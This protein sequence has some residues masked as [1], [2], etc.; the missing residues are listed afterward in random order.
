M[1]RDRS[2]PWRNSLVAL[3]MLM[4]ACATP[5][6]DAAREQGRP[7]EPDSA[8]EAG[9]EALPDP[10]PERTPEPSPDIPERPEPVPDPFAPEPCDAATRSAIA[11][12]VSAQ[13]DAFAGGDVDGAYAW[14]SPFFRR[15]VDREAFASLISSEYPWL[16]GNA[17]HRLDECG[18]RSRRAFLVAGVRAEGQEQVLRYDL[19][20]EPDGWRIDGAMSLQGV[21]LPPPDRVA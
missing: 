6:P 2:T 9:P 15:L 21:T 20:L 11:A 3:A 7:A 4:A 14:T 16:L 8:P 12:T 1:R 17:G 10:D 13:L 19:S 18:V 5:D